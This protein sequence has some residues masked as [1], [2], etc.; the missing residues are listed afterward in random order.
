MEQNADIAKVKGML[1]KHKLWLIVPF[2]SLM[3]LILAVALLLPDIYRSSAVIMVEQSQVP[4][5]L[6]PSTVTSFADQRIQAITQEVTSRTKILNLVSK[7]DLLPDKR[8]K[9]TAEDLVEKIQKRITIEPIDAEIKKETQTKPILLTIAFR[10]S[11][12]DEEPGKAQKVTNELASYYMGKNLEERE[13]YARTTSKFLQDQLQQVKAKVDELETKLADYREKHLEELPEFTTLNMQKVEKLN[14][15]ISNLNMQVRSMEEQRAAVKSRLAIVDPWSSDRVLSY[16]DRLQQAQLERAAL[17]A[18]YS[19]KHPLVQAKNQ[20]ISLLGKKGGD[21]VKLAQTRD[22]LQTLQLEAA[23]LKARYTDQHP[24]VK[25]KNLEIEK[26][27]HD[28]ALLQASSATPRASSNEKATNPAY[29]ALESDLEKLGVSVVSAKTEIKRLEKQA[30]DVY[31]KLRA[32]PSVS[33]EYNELSTDYQNAKAQYTDLQQK[34]MAAQVSQGL[35]EEQL[36][37][38]FQIIEP[39]FFPEKPVKPNR[40]AIVLIGM[41]LGAAFSVGCLTLAEH[42]DK[43]IRDVASLERICGNRLLSVIPKIITE[44]DRI[45]ARRK[46]AALCTGTVVGV[47]VVI[48]AFH[49]LVMDLYVLSAKI[50]RFVQRTF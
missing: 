35:E 26:V 47:V 21:P 37:E 48:C 23:D 24:E 41:F 2:I 46:K 16:E 25:K 18:K 9:L 28:L 19:E 1:K 14:S 40:L 11:Y 5:N 6:V 45:L 39:A 10:L 17:V 13:K 20:E 49:F 30:E 31:V 12:D 8:D 32:M 4:Q 15:D 34:F 7:Y 27:R 43:S 29:V 38:T 33:K 36:G 50:E 3:V 44:K 22:R 42:A